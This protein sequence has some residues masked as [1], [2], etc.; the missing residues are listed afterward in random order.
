[1]YIKN[2]D[3]EDLVI[4]EWPAS[5]TVEPD[6]QKAFESKNENRYFV[7]IPTGYYTTAQALGDKLRRE[8]MDTKKEDALLTMLAHTAGGQGAKPPADDSGQQK[9]FFDY[10][11]QMARSRFRAKTANYAIAATTPDFFKKLGFVPTGQFKPSQDSDSYYMLFI[12]KKSKVTATA[13]PE[14]NIYHL[15]KIYVDCIEETIVANTLTQEIG[16]VTIPDYRGQYSNVFYN[17][18]YVPLNKNRIETIKMECRDTEGALFPLYGGHVHAVFHLR[19]CQ[20]TI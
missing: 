18:R 12:P 9:L 1:V 3:K 20:L 2:F 14:L 11:Y 17:L 16:T 13:P 19:R 7:T 8:L 5:E 4:Y 6:Y 15:M 10:D